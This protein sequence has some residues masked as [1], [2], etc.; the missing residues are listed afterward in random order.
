MST[1]FVFQLQETRTLQPCKEKSYTYL[2]HRNTEQDPHISITWVLVRNAESLGHPGP[3]IRSCIC[4]RV[5]VVSQ[6]HWSWRDAGLER[7]QAFVVYICTRIIL[8]RCFPFNCRCSAA[9]LQILPNLPQANSFL[10]ENHC[11][12]AWKLEASWHNDTQGQPYI[13]ILNVNRSLHTTK[14]HLCNV[15]WSSKMNIRD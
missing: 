7:F 8:W 5:W 13:R 12:R 2:L 15:E 4:T 3:V 11:P 9:S 1:R 10:L 6:T 14:D